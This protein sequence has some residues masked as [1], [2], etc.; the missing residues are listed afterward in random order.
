MIVNT[1]VSN[2]LDSNMYLIKDGS[3]QKARAIIFDPSCPPE[4]VEDIDDIDIEAIFLT[5]SHFDH[6][7]MLDKWMSFLKGR[8]SNPLVFIGEGEITYPSNPIKN[9]SS[10]FMRPISIN[11]P[12]QPVS[13]MTNKSF[14]ND[15]VSLEVIDTPGHSPSSKSYLISVDKKVLISGDTLFAGGVGRTDMFGGNEKS[16]Y[17]SILLLKKLEDDVIILPG[18]GHPSTIGIEKKSNPMMLM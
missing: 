9:L 8:D 7:A 12:I 11:S 14:L 6:I 13:K 2:F 18:H 3:H 17:E 15:S 16:L 4:I 1:Y 5:H 10:L